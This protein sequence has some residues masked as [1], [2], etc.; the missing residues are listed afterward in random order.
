MEQATFDEISSIQYTAVNN[1][2]C[3]GCIRAKRDVMISY[4]SNDNKFLDIFLTQSQAEE[5]IIQLQ[6]SITQNA[7]EDNTNSRT[8]LIEKYRQH[9]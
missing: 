6:K 9:K 8:V 5:L 2:H 7:I 4:V 3:N 1:R